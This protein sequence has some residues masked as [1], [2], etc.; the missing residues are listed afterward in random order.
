MA[1]GEIDA[2]VFAGQNR[3]GRIV[4]HILRELLAGREA[5][6]DGTTDPARAAAVADLLRRTRPAEDEGGPEKRA[7]C[8]RLARL[9]EGPAPDLKAVL[10]RSRTGKRKHDAGGDDDSAPAVP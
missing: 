5:P 4:E 8:A 2:A 9:A 3:Q 6:L 7:F 1:R 10:G